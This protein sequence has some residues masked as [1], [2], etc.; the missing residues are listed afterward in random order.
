[1]KVGLRIVGGTIVD[2]DRGING[3]GDVLINGHRIVEAGPHESVSADNTIDAHGC[4]VLPGLI[5]FHAHLFDGGTQSG[6]HADTALIPMGVTTGVDAGSCG[7]ANY[8]S[9]MRS[10]VA[11]SKVRLFG[12]VNVSPQGL[13]ATAYGEQLDPKY[14]DERALAGLFDRYRGRCLGLKIRYQK[15]L[16]R[17]HGR[18]ALQRTL[19]IADR[20]QCPV[21]VHT[22]NPASAPDDIAAVLR[23]GDVYC[24]MY[25]GTGD[26]ILGADGVVG[27][28]LFRAQESGVLFDSSMGRLNF[29]FNVARA[30]LAQGFQPDIISSDLTRRTL[31]ADY[32]FS[33]PFVMMK[34]LAMG[35]SLPAVVAA[36]T[37]S[38]ARHIGMKGRLGT[39]ASGAFADVA[40]FR[41]AK[42]HPVVM[43]DIHGGSI[44]TDDW[45]I[46]QMTVLDGAVAYRQIDFQ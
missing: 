10:A 45:L 29:S 15:E 46:P 5:D 12:F 13:I 36:C 37:S 16:V 19:E 35:L 32:V 14:Y 7:T 26:T 11:A 25:Q 24:H 2:P 31:Y 40:I 42:G 1:M 34:F 38:P 41:R 27:P 30:A 43:K 23:A 39:L 8:D 44:T 4:L 3:P 22:T 6:V 28:A 33:L 21:V 9:F 20:L 17:E 18:A